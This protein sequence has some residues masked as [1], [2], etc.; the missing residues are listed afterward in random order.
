MLGGK[1]ETKE[2]RKRTRTTK[3][4]TSNSSNMVEE[5]TPQILFLGR[6]NY[7]LFLRML[8]FKWT[9]IFKKSFNYLYSVKHKEITDLFLLF[10][11]KVLMV[12]F[13]SVCLT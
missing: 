7:L 2:E 1:T 12:F 13:Y 10:C 3:Q 5:V 11:F 8:Y 9:H 6:L 4:N